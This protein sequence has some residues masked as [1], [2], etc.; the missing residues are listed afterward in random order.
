MALAPTTS[1]WSVAS[2]WALESDFGA[3]RLKTEKS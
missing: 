3:P 2:L 1:L